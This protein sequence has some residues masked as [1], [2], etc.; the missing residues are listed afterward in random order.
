[1]NDSSLNARNI[2]NAN[3]HTEKETRLICLIKS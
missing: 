2:T 1:M 3:M